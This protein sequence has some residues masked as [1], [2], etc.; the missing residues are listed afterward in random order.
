MLSWNC[1]GKASY[2]RVGL[3]FVRPH[4]TDFPQRVVKSKGNSLFQGNVGWW[5]YKLTRSIGVRNQSACFFFPVHQLP[6]DYWSPDYHYFS[7]KSNG[8]P[9]LLLLQNA[10][11]IGKGCFLPAMLVYQSLAHIN[12]LLVFEE[13]LKNLMDMLECLVGDF[14]G[15]FADNSQ[16]VRK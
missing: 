10:F 1:K 12:G 3:R 13:T 5:Y 6:T 8:C 16:H 2:G 11:T 14:F 9:H 15:C 4:M 7:T